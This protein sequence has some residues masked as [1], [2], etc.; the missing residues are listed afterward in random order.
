MSSKHVQQQQWQAVWKEGR[1]ISVAIKV[2]TVN[3]IGFVDRERRMI[4]NIL[5]VA[6]NNEVSYQLVENPRA[7]AGVAIINADD[8]VAMQ[9]WNEYRQ[10]VPGISVIL[11]SAAPA[12]ESDYICIKRPLIASQL[13]G[14]LALSGGNA[15]AA[16]P[17]AQQK[18]AALRRSLLFRNFSSVHLEKIIALSRILTL[19][20]GQAVFSRADAGEE[21]FVVLG[22]RLKVSVC[23][24]EGHDIMLGVVGPGEILGEIAMLDGLGRSAGATTL[25]PSELL[26][27]HRR[28]FMPFLEQNSKAA[29]DL[30]RVLALR[31]RLNTEQLAELI[32]DSTITR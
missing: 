21:M 15:T 22:G 6:S 7:A 9:F 5:S 25:A 28:D 20:A 4:R 32:A 26:V 10:D 12:L 3:T 2:V 24:R 1:D 29:I 17:P 27:I 16:T 23:D 30:I 14:A 31:L 8:A 13:H 19:S 18:M 11:A